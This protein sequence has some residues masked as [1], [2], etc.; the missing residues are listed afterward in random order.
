[1]MICA[2][3]RLIS[4]CASAQSDQSLCYPPEGALEY[5]LSTECPA[6]ILVR[7]RG[8]KSFFMLNSAEREIFHANKSQ[9][10]NNCKFFLAKHS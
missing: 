3:R 10:S 4:A 1:M 2:Q 7:S 8:Y 5:W 6:K 9:T